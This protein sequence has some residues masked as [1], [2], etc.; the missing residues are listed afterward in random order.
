MPI[1]IKEAIEL[2]INNKD[3]RKEIA[4]KSFDIVNREFS[5]GSLSD[6]FDN[7]MKCS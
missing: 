2:L 1:K 7:I 5:F 3:L 4:N 6:K